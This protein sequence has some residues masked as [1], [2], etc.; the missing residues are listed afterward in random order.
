MPIQALDPAL[1]TNAAPLLAGGASQAVAGLN[2]DSNALASNLSSE[3]ITRGVERNLGLESVV[4]QGED[5]IKAHESGMSAQERDKRVNAL[6]STLSN[7][8]PGQGSGQTPDVVQE[9]AETMK[10]LVKAL[11][12]IM[13][14]LFAH[15]TADPSEDIG[16]NE[17]IWAIGKSGGGSSGYGPQHDRLLELLTAKDD[18][19]QKAAQ[20]ATRKHE[21]ALDDGLNTPQPSSARFKTLQPGAS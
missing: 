5:L 6:V 1:R 4:R 16:G 9:A 21:A 19:F 15:G 12:R 8:R 10:R 13:R 18:E 7:A 17:P 11:M 3:A 14:S 20:E 2:S